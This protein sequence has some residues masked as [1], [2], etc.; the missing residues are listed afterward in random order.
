[1]NDAGTFESLAIEQIRAFFTSYGTVLVAG[2]TGTIARCHALPT[3]VLSDAGS[4]PITTTQEIATAF[5]AAADGYRIR[6]L[7]SARPVLG[8]IEPLSAEIVSTDVEW[9]YLDARGDVAAREAY[10]YLLRIRPNDGIQIQVVI[11]R[12]SI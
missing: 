5:R 11:A 2:D 12:P 1:M 4:L 10:R 3:L 8:T 7:V 9:D 6:G